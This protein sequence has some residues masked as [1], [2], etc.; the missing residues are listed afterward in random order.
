MR[1]DTDRDLPKLV[2]SLLLILPGFTLRFGLQAFWF[3]HKAYKAARIFRRE[4]NHQGMDSTTTQ[5]LTNFYLEGSD[6]F[7]LIKAFR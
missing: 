7:K 6:P 1:R 4:L 3:K 2:G 5:R